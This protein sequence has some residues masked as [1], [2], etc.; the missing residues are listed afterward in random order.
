LFCQTFEQLYAFYLER[1]L[2]SSDAKEEAVSDARR[3]V[4]MGASLASPLRA[5]GCLIAPII[6]ALLLL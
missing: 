1:T 6:G 4:R 2:N 3:L 5:R